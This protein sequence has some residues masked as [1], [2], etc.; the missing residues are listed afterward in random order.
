MAGASKQINNGTCLTFGV[1]CKVLIS[2]APTLQDVVSICDRLSADIVELCRRS[3]YSRL[4]SLSWPR[5]SAQQQS[6]LAALHSL[7]GGEF[8]LVDS[9]I[10]ATVLQMDGF[11][12]P[13]SPLLMS[14]VQAAL[15]QVE[16]VLLE[17]VRHLPDC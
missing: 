17:P 13:P 4:S 16:L 12:M 9:D 3:L 8:P 15:Q 2:V 1:L 10:A 14:L 11:R 6:D 5:D 7:A